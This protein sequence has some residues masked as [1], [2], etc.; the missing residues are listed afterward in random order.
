MTA[1]GTFDSKE[2]GCWIT[3]A[4]HRAGG[5]WTTGGISRW[6]NRLGDDLGVV[7]EMIHATA[8]HAGSTCPVRGA[9]G[10]AASCKRYRHAWGRGRR[11]GV[12]GTTCF[13]FCRVS[14]GMATKGFRTLTA[15]GTIGSKEGGCWITAAFHRVGG[16]WMTGGT[17]RW[18]NRLGDDLG[19]VTEMIHAMACH[20]GSMRLVRGVS[21]CAASCKR[22]RHAL[23]R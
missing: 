14:A 10:C 12:K 7:T 20:A 21:G 19:V 3:A 16:S 8:C 4:I 6:P 23:G 13:R 5:S 18:P 1:S 17:S 22:Y 11:H 2:G 9:S 15:S